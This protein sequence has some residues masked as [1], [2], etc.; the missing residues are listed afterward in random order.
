MANIL[1]LGSTGYIGGRL[2]PRL[3][4]KG[5]RVR[6]LVRDPR[7]VLGRKWLGVEVMAGDVLVPE[8]LV[9]AMQGMDAVYYLVHSM[10]AGEKHFE[11][12]DRQAARYVGDAA[13]AAGVKRIIYLGGL[14]RRG[15]VISAHLKSRHEVGDIL[16]ESKVP[17]TEFRAA[18]IIGSGGVSFEMMHHLVN[19][20]PIMICPRWVYVK[21]QPIAMRD[22]QRYLVDCL[23][24]PESAGR[25]LD[26]GGPDIMT[27]GE[28]M[29]G[30]ARALGLKRILI[31]V[32]VLTPLLSSYWVNFITPLP[33]T[34]ARILIEGLQSETVC[35]NHDALHIFDFQPMS[36][37]DSL[38]RTL[39][40]LEKQTVETKWTDA[41]FHYEECQDIDPSHLFIDRREILVARSAEK[42]FELIQTIG[43]NTGWYQYD[44]LW[45]LRGF[46]DRQLGGVGLRRGRR[47]PHELQVG[48]ALDF[49]RVE[50]F[51]P[52]HKLLLRA[53]MKVP[54][55]AWLEFCVEPADDN[56]SQ[57]IQTAKF[58]PRGLAGFA[59]WFLLYPVH[60]L[61]F[62]GT[63]QAIKKRAEQLGG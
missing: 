38:R 39:A 29:L 33:K 34:V 28:M 37:E 16:R 43:G 44:W 26:I 53:E 18:V 27:Y 46:I 1:V 63:M 15:E 3:V 13:R 32:P 50:E 25:V 5:H 21:T 62:R 4:L 36:F 51:V 42:L 23:D 45:R 10:S 17:V 8:T 11:E 47:H 12:R 6:C 49:W 22:V 35:E 48:D 30:L 58:Y 59:Y 61:I 7:K 31:P 9:P 14:G 54:G 40:R 56:H 24:K 2:V 60:M 41:T 19:R 20:L 52:G 57:L 55:R